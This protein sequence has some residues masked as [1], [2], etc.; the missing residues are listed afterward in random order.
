[1]LEAIRT[2][3]DNIK[4]EVLENIIS[5]LRKR[6]TFGSFSEERMQLVLEGTWDKVEYNLMM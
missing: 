1:M 4:K 5:D 6:G 3:K 2:S